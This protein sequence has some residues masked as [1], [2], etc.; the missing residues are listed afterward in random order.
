MKA[1]RLTLKLGYTKHLAV[2][3]IDAVNG[4]VMPMDDKNSIMFGVS[5]N[6]TGLVMSNSPKK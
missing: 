6:G 1:L 2:A 5:R 4:P 3:I